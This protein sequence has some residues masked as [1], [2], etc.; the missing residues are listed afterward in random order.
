VLYGYA[1]THCYTF[2]MRSATAD[3]PG[4]SPPIYPMGRAYPIVMVGSVKPHGVAQLNAAKEGCAG[5][6]VTAFADADAKHLGLICHAM[7]GWV[8]RTVTVCGAKR[9]T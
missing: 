1:W 4:G 3:Q 6:I 2:A 9:G 5:A 8:P 7:A